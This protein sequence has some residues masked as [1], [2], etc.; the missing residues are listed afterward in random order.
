MIKKSAFAVVV[1]FD[2]DNLKKSPLK[3][4]ALNLI[5]VAF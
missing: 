4:R 2:Q 1:K 3:K 5:F